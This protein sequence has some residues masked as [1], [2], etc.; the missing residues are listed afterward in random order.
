MH[1]SSSVLLSGPTILK[2]HLAEA[3]QELEIF[4]KWMQKW[5]NII[6]KH[7]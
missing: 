3:E 6:Q 2:K 1:N 7:L 5:R 4:L